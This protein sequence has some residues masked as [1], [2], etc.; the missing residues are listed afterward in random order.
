MTQMSQSLTRDSKIFQDLFRDRGWIVY[1]F[2][3]DQPVA[4]RNGLVQVTQPEGPLFY[5]H[6]RILEGNHRSMCKFQ[7]TDDNGYKQV[8]RAIESIV[9]GSGVEGS[10]VEGSRKNELSCRFS[11][12]SPR[13]RLAPPEDFLM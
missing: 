11:L 2:F 12:S 8:S 10:R 9:S 6:L 13:G 1:T 5:E 7:T 3:E 4:T